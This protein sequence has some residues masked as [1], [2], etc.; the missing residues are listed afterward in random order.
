MKPLL[1]FGEALIDFLHTG[2]TQIGGLNLP[3]FRQFPGGAPA[4]V[5]VAFSRLG[6]QALF[7]GQVGDDVFGRFLEESLAH[8]GVDN[9][10]LHKHPSANTALAFVTLDDDG[11]RSFSFYRDRTADVLFS[12]D[13]I[14][15]SWFVNGPIF[16]VCS[17]TLTNADI[18]AVTGQA[19][20]R[21]SEEGCVISFDANLRPGLWP[22]GIV[23]RA[24]CDTLARSAGFVKFAREEIEFLANG[25]IERYVDELLEGSTRL[26]VVTAGGGPVEYFVRQGRGIIDTPRV[27]VVDTTAA[28]DAFTAGVLRGLCAASE[29]DALADDLRS[30]ELLVSFA[31]HCGSLTTTRAGAFPSLPVFEE[32]A[33]HWNDMP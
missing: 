29:L 27:D 32:V 16:H 13:Q 9:R 10:F 3:D 8:Y 25:E 31:V 7:A 11:D 23:D 5:A 1:C 26:V 20:E 4:N 12:V 6:G 22:G 30:V 33:Q 18:A 19:V 24:S 14:G 15:D 2:S 28:G 17:N 21:A